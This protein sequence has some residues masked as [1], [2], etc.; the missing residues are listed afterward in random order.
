M[1]LRDRFRDSPRL[2][3]PYDPTH[4]LREVERLTTHKAR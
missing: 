3:K 2:A 1:D 4:L